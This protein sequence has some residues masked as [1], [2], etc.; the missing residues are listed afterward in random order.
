MIKVISMLWVVIIKDDARVQL[1]KVKFMD[2]K[3]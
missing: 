2:I 3:K 1:S